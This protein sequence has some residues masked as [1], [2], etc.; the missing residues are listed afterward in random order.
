MRLTVA[1]LAALLLTLTM[2]VG[3]SY[4]RA[5]P[6]VQTLATAV[7]DKAVADPRLCQVFADTQ[8]APAAGASEA[9]DTLSEVGDGAEVL[10]AGAL[11]VGPTA[12]PNTRAAMSTR[13]APS[14]WLDG[15]L[16]PP[17]TLNG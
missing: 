8:P 14:H 2:L 5:A 13:D 12:Q 1:F 4:G 9:R 11:A 16:R 6:Q 10:A 15:L 7:A 17:R 3:Q